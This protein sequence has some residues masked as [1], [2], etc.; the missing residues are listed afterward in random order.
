MTSIDGEFE[1]G[2]QS[3]NIG[4]QICLQPEKMYFVQFE[5]DNSPGASLEGYGFSTTEGDCGM[6]NDADVCWQNRV[7]RPV[8]HPIV[9][10]QSMIS[11]VNSV[12]D[13]PWVA[14]AIICASCGMIAL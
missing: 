7:R 10:T 1:F 4:G 11:C 9:S 8:K 14:I 13:G 5:L 3:D 6:T 12:S 2:P